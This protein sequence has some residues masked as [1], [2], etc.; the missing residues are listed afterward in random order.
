MCWTSDLR[1]AEEDTTVIVKRE[2]YLGG[3]NV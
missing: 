1:S 3:A 2:D